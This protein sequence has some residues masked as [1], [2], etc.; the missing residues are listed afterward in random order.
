MF[1]RVSLNISNFGRI[2]KEFREEIE[3]VFLKKYGQLEPSKLEIQKI[4]DSV[5]EDRLIFK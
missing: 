5:N 2:T 1:I 4:I 3:E